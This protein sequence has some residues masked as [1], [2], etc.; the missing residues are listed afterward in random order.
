VFL[1]LFSKAS[2]FV[3]FFA[4]IP[5]DGMFVC[6]DCWNAGSVWLPV[7]YWV[8]FASSEFMYL[9]FDFVIRCVWL[10][11]FSMISIQ[12][13]SLAV[14]LFDHFRSPFYVGYLFVFSFY[15]SAYQ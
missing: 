6:S 13:T 15:S 12:S 5:D 2:F 8:A 1:F 9:T 7:C 3:F 4:L 11:C 14:V 10:F